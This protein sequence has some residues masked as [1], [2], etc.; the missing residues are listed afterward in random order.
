M[1]LI[2]AAAVL[3]GLIV[4]NNDGG[5]CWFQDERAIVQGNRLIVGSVA[6][7]SRDPDR[8][9]DIEV[10]S[11]D[12]STGS[13]TRVRLHPRLASED[14]AYDD[15]NAPAFLTRP[16][17]RILAVYA[18]HGSENRFYY[19]VSEPNDATEWGPISEFSPSPSSRITYSNL[20]YLETEGRTYN[21]FRG[22]DD[23]YRPS[24]V[25]SDDRGDHWATGTIV[26][27]N[28]TQERHRPYV[29]YASDGKSSIHL[30]FTD[31]HPHVFPNSIYHVVYRDG[32]LRRSDGSTIIPLT[33]GLPS[34]DTGTRVYQGDSD[35]IAW[36]SDLHLDADLNPYLAFSV[37]RGGTDVPIGTG[38]LDHRYF[39]ARWNG[40]EWRVDEIAF[41]GTRLYWNEDHYTG[42]IA[43]DPSDPNTVYISTNADPNTGRPLSSR[44]DGGRHWEIFRGSTSDGGRTWDW[45]AITRNSRYDNIRPIVPEWKEG[46]ALLWLRGTYSTYTNYDLEVVGRMHRR[47]P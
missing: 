24:F 11:F 21:F 31:G 44:A 43:L 1:L 7:G 10:V 38:G 35:H 20:L 42:N 8:Q 5:W 30:A 18:K 26:I 15:H 34:P 32:Q 14:D 22:L 23:S 13:R 6:S 9:G 33:D 37:H 36:I 25:I 4:V 47:E 41:G 29:K 12:L 39:R 28:R 17:G 19:R 3:S 45:E 2:G 46:T 16:D 40:S 27:R